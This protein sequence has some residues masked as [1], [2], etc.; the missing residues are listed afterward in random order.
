MISLTI[1][2]RALSVLV[3]SRVC[4]IPKVA[5]LRS[6]RLSYVL[7]LRTYTHTLSI[8][9]FIPDILSSALLVA[10]RYLEP[11]T[12]I[13]LIAMAIILVIMPDTIH[14]CKKAIT[15]V[16]TITLAIR[17]TMYGVVSTLSFITLLISIIPHTS[18]T[19]LKPQPIYISILRTLSLPLPLTSLSISFSSIS[20]PSAVNRLYV[21]AM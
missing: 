5:S 13:T 16:T 2:S 14:F 7:S 8:W 18:R 21:Y 15:P 10:P 3:R 12:I 20:C 11:I 9:V 19:A 4:E 6:S 17:I 1:M